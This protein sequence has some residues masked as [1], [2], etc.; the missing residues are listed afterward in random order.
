MSRTPVEQIAIAVHDESNQHV[1]VR[2]VGKDRDVTE[3][4]PEAPVTIG[5]RM[6][7]MDGETGSCMSQG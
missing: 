3:G 7:V 2:Q 4:L 1:Y 5:L 6:E